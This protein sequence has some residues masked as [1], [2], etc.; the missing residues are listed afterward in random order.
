M[1]Q[2]GVYE[3]TNQETCQTFP[4][5]LDIQ[6]DVLNDLPT[7]VVVPLVLSSL[8]KKSIPILTPLFR[9]CE[10]EVLMLTPQLVGVQMQVLGTRVCSLKEQRSDIIAALDLLITGF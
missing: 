8:L 10:S 9:I 1:A 4:Y 6:A 3:N 7:R 2:Y 5:M